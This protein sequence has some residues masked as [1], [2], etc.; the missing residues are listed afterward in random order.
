M[1]GA[2][3]RAAWLGVLKKLPLLVVACG[4]VVVVH[5]GRSVVAQ[6]VLADASGRLVAALL[7]DDAC[8]ATVWVGHVCTAP[9]TVH[10][11]A[12][13]GLVDEVCAAGDVVQRGRLAGPVLQLARV[14]DQPHVHVVALCE[15]LHLG[16]HAADVLCLRHV[17]RARVV[18]L[19]V[20]VDDEAA[21]AVPADRRRR[22]VQH[23][24]DRRRLLHRRHYALHVR[25]HPRHAASVAVAEAAAIAAA[26][27]AA[28][29]DW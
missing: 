3:V 7:H 11:D 29:T 8:G 23:P 17:Q 9:V 22:F 25:G 27:A 4:C 26:A 1:A 28:S 15:A 12:A 14:H 13:V 20:W 6:L 21:D 19:V 5:A 10:D 24:V 2:H 18:E 16:E